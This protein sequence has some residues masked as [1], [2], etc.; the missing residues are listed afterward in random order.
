MS[1]PVLEFLGFAGM[2]GCGA[3]AAMMTINQLSK[4]DVLHKIETTAAEHVIQQLL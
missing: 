4:A 3:T 2:V 1:Q